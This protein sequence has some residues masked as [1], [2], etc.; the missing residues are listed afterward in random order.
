MKEQD[1]KKLEEIARESGIH[2]IYLGDGIHPD[3]ELKQEAVKNIIL[4]RLMGYT[5]ENCDHKGDCSY[6]FGFDDPGTRVIVCGRC[7]YESLV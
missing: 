7:G 6:N 5:P 4:G 1:A 3:D 2:F